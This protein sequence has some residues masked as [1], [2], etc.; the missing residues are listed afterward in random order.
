MPQTLEQLDLLLLTVAKPRKVQRHGIE[1]HGLRYVDLAL[2]DYV[3]EP[4]TV[5]Y[6][7]QDLAEIRVFHH[8]RFLCRA[9]NAELAAQTISL[10]ELQAAR[11]ARRRELRAQLRQRRS[12]VDALDP[13]GV[14]EVP[15]PAGP[16][17]SEK[18]PPEPQPSTSRLRRYAEE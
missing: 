15:P 16:I 9:V 1:L 14:R 3:G 4:V 11:T 7:P 18:P 8:D 2:A 10:R 6:D 12:L 13:A 5:R 17:V